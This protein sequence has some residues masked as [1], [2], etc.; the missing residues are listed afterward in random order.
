MNPLESMRKGFL[1][2]LLRWLGH[3]S[4]K[5]YPFPPIQTASDRGFFSFREGWLSPSLVLSTSRHGTF[6]VRQNY[7]FVELSPSHSGRFWIP[8]LT[9]RIM[10]PPPPKTTQ[11]PTTKTP[12]PNPHHPPPPQPP[13]PPTP[14]PNRVYLLNGTGYASGKNITALPQGLTLVHNPTPFYAETCDSPSFSP[15]LRTRIT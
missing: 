11:P 12:H 2:L 7:P 1:L 8:S 15:L 10:A 4:L 6:F 14:P 5:G 13:T 9:E 3:T